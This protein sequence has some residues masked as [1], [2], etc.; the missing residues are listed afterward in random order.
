MAV[1]DPQ[2]CPDVETVLSPT[3]LTS[4]AMLGIGRPARSSLGP[5]ICRGTPAPDIAE[6]ITGVLRIDRRDISVT[7]H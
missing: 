5:C 6:L 3:P 2:E 7:L 4:F 1:G